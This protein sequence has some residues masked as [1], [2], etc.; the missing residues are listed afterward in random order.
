[1]CRA[2]MIILARPSIS[3]YLSKT[4]F[5][6]GESAILAEDIKVPM[7]PALRVEPARTL[8]ERPKQAYQSLILTSSENALAF[9][10]DAIPHDDR[11]LKARLFKDKVAFRRSLT[12]LYPEFF[13]AET[14]LAGLGDLDVKKLAFPLV[15]KP[16]AGISS[17]GVR[18]VEKAADWAA[19][20]AFIRDDVAKYAANYAGIVVD[21]QKVIVEE[22]IP[23][24]ELA[25]DC[26]Y[27]G[28]AE[29]VI[30]N[31]MEH[32][33]RDAADT[34]D[35]VYYTRRSLVRRHY[36]AIHDFLVR[37][38]DLFDLKRFPMHLELRLTPHGKLVPIEVNP[39]RFAG[40]GTTEIAEYAYA[41]NV[42]KHFF[43]ETRPD[44]DAIL[45]D[46]DDSVYTFLCTDVPTEKFR[47]AGLRVDDRA[48]WRTFG[49]VLEYRILDEVETSTFAVIFLR[50]DDL[51]EN[52]RIL[53]LDLERYLHA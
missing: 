37:L 2:P 8:F 14:T 47:K 19:A 43:R 24:T 23:G 36:Q 12:K 27:D 35:L 5:E 41:I 21:G 6:L 39:L 28:K 22:W 16:A 32:M 7:R 46:E 48:L 4:L 15:I 11:V 13:F 20:V 33:F 31:V 26:Y 45:A 34:S 42:Y 49:E 10:Q 9:L 18:R 50:S 51:E 44:W 38:G 25:V 3:P 17:I 53:S 1:M 29:P 40:L 52:R 30:L